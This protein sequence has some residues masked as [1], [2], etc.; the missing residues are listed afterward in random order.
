MA[1][2]YPYHRFSHGC[3]L[4]PMY[5]LKVEQDRLLRQTIQTQLEAT[6]WTP[7]AAL[8]P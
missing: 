6:T 4:E 7:F 5:T 8:T 2:S 1:L 3:G